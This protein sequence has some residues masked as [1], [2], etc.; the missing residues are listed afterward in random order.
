MK[1]C[2][3]LSKNMA[4]EHKCSDAIA[5]IAQKSNN[6]RTENWHA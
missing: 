4:L 5:K 2:V 1:Y 6:Y 3:V